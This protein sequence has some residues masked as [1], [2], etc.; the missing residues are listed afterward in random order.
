MVLESMLCMSVGVSCAPSHARCAFFI[1][2]STDVVKHSLSPAHNL[3]LQTVSH[4]W[5]ARTDIQNEIHL[6]QGKKEL[7]LLLRYHAE[8]CMGLV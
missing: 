3:L 6:N 2:G 7:S 8:G 5:K 4:N 1:P